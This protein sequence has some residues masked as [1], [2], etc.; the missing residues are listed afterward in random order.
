MI[1]AKNPFDKMGF[2]L[3]CFGYV[4]MSHKGLEDLSGDSLFLVTC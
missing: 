2:L 4:S 1:V 3:L